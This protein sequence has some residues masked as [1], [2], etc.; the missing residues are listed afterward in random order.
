MQLNDVQLNN[1][2]RGDMQGVRLSLQHKK[3]RTFPRIFTHHSQ[4]LIWNRTVKVST[5][6]S[7]RHQQVNRIF[8]NSI[9]HIPSK[10]K[11]I[12]SNWNRRIAPFHYLYIWKRR[13]RKM[14][15]HYGKSKRIRQPGQILI[16]TLV[17]LMPVAMRAF[18]PPIQPTPLINSRYQ[19][20]LN[21]AENPANQNEP[22]FPTTTRTSN[23]LRKPPKRTN[24]KAKPQ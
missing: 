7:H 6:H 11:H 10:S 17:L 4:P 3:V 9:V 2:S 22:I 16:C 13:V 20:L 15:E 5:H 19:T 24:N 1:Y 14:L 12:L 21:K 18:P 8:N 23:D